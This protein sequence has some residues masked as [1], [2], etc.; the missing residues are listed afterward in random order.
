[1]KTIEV[2]FADVRNIITRAYPGAK[3][4]RTVKI[5]GQDS[6][7]V[8]DFWDGGSRDECRFV[9]LGSLRV[10]SSSE[11]PYG[12]RQRQSNPYNLPICDVNL[13]SGY[14]VVE[15]VIFC[16]KDLGYRIY[17]SNARFSAMETGDVVKELTAPSTMLPALPVSD[18]E[19]HTIPAPYSSD[20]IPCPPPSHLLSV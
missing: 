13:T 8:R 11:I 9:E 1:M 19:R 16:G 17:V 3:S 20:T 18:E 14:C 2:K 12:V 4:R 6:Y 5:Q 10:M 15:H 7:S